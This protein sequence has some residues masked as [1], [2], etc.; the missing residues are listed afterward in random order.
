MFRSF[1][2]NHQELS[3][4]SGSLCFYLHIMVTAVLCS[5]SGRPVG[6]RHD[7]K[8]KPKAASA[9]IEL[10]IMGGKTPETC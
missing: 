3:D 1:P 2:A 10:L 7:T 9:V 8:V 6:Y 4:C 5:W